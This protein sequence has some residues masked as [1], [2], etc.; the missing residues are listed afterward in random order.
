MELGRPFDTTVFEQQDTVLHCAHDFT[1]GAHQCNVVG[2][3]AWM[4]TAAQLGVGHQLFL[5]SY[6]ARPDADSEYGRTKYEIERLF[7]DSGYAVLRPGLVTGAGGLFQ[8]QRKVLLRSSVVPMLGDGTQPVAA[9][10]LE[11]FLAASTV[12]IEERRAGAFNL[13]YEA[14]PTYRQFVSG[15]REGRRTLFLPVPIGVALTLASIAE[16]LHLPIPVKP[17]QIRALKGNRTSPWRSDLSAL[18]ATA[19]A[20]IDR[21]FP[22]PG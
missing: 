7:L 1:L 22:P 10:S 6:S 11:H 19:K 12:V 4:T 20:P 14:M 15:V 17:G 3:N 2:T 13:F 21:R 8:R 9:I 16:W 18:L 5:S